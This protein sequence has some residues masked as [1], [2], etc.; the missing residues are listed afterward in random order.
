MLA[1]EMARDS[2][3]N[4]SI[5]T[6]NH[7]VT[8]WRMCGETVSGAKAIRF[9]SAP[10]VLWC[11]DPQHAAATAW[12][13]TFQRMTDPIAFTLRLLTL[14]MFE[15]SGRG[16]SEHLERQPLPLRIWAKRKQVRCPA[17]IALLSLIAAI[18]AV[19]TR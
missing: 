19:S 6:L 13:L 17:C 7:P 16:M 4:W 18:G 10:M 5:D 1:L 8:V 2:W 3:R 14:A 9:G 11:R 15:V 12:L